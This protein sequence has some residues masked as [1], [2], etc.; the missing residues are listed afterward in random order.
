MLELDKQDWKDRSM[1]D[2][3]DT[4]CEECHMRG[5]T[6]RDEWYLICLTGSDGLPNE[7]RNKF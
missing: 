6:E 1:R 4:S 2:Q 3:T 5:C 7:I